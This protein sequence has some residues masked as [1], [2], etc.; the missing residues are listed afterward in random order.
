MHARA[1]AVAKRWAALDLSAFARQ[2]SNS[3]GL[4]RLTLIHAQGN[5]IFTDGG[6]AY[7]FTFPQF[8]KRSETSLHVV[9]R[10]VEMDST[11]PT[12]PP[13]STVPLD[14]DL[15]H[16]GSWILTTWEYREVSPFV[17]G[18]DDLDSYFYL[19]ET[20]RRIHNLSIPGLSRHDPLQWT[21]DRVQHLADNHGRKDLADT[22]ARL[23]EE[24]E[25]L[26]PATHDVTVHGDVHWH[27]TVQTEDGRVLLLDF[28]NAALGHPSVDV[29]PSGGWVRRTGQ[30]S[31]AQMNALR[32]GYGDP[33]V[34][35]TPA[36]EELS[37]EIA[38]FSILTWRLENIP[39]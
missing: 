19:G 21:R 18:S 11:F 16:L 36:Q 25:K 29:F 3:L 5:L 38:E 9:Q 26:F 24:Q 17:P 27:Q 20:I 6:L 28:E 1:V 32:Q 31:A 10:I 14:V 30:P 34:A 13:V 37:R 8:R 22:V 23:S 39:G 15:G 35:L 2:V 7:K 4:P 12:L 33:W